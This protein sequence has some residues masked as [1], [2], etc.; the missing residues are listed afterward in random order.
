MRTFYGCDAHKKYSLFVGMDEA[1]HTGSPVRVEHERLEFRSFLET[2]P[3]NSPIALETVGNWYWMIEEIEKAGHLP[4]LTHARKAK[5]MMGEINKTDKLDA[6]GLAL[7]MRNGTLPSVWIPPGELRDQRELPRMRMALVRVRTMLKNRIHACLAKF[8]IRIE[9]V[10]DLFGVRGRQLLEKRLMELPPYTRRSVEVQLAVLDQVEEQIGRCEKQIQE[11][12]A[13]TPEMKLLMTEPGVGM[14]LA[15]VIALEIGKVDRFPNCERLASYAGTVPRVHSSGGRT[16]Y[17]RVRPDVNRYL[18]WAFVEAAN[19]IVLQQHRLPDHH[20]IRLYRR[21]RASKGHGKAIVAVARHLAE[22][23]YWVLKKGE[24]Y[25]E[26]QNHKVPLPTRK[27]A[28]RSHESSR[29][30]H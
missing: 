10:T 19:G 22:A 7:L 28:R 30:V 21:I 26:P 24:P 9:E 4:F 27:E 16:Y 15:I 29:L 17:G 12:V 13:I 1:G 2:L 3:P 11:V 18:K 25:R 14:I 20:A 5:L 6:R 8:A 23:T